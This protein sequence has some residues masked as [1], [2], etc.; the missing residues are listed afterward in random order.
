MAGRLWSVAS[1]LVVG[2]AC[3]GWSAPRAAIAAPA[4]TAPPEVADTLAQIEAAANAQDLESVMAFYG[5]GF[6]HGDGFDRSQ[7][8]ATLGEVWAAYQNL[9]Y[10]VEL[11]SWEPMGS[12]FVVETLTTITG[13][14]LE[15]GRN[16]TLRAT[17]RSRQ[18]LEAGQLVSQEVLAEQSRL[19]LGNAAPTVVVQLPETV[20]VNARYGFDAIVQEP[21]GNRVLLGRAFEEGVTSEDFLTPRPLTLDSLSAGGLFKIGRAPG[22][23]DQ[24]WVSSV[25]VGADGWVIDTRRL[26]VTAP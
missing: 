1:V 23:A 11:L 24:R 8:A 4:E 3:W 22:K 15:D 10:D 21:L 14:R 20:R 12:G 13:T 7:Y 9:Q 26:T 6:V 18:R 19:T 2:A 5:A 17:V 16:F 25:I